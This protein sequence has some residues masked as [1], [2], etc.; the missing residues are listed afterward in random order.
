[1]ERRDY[2]L[3]EIEKIGLLLRMLLN[4][5]TSKSENTSISIENQ[6]EEE[7]ELFLNE[8]GFDIDDFLSLQTSGIE[9]YLSKFSGIRGANIELLADVLREIGMKYKSKLSKAYLEKALMLYE[10]CNS[11]DKTYSFDRERKIIEIKDIIR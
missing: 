6:F 5:I 8:M 2:L 4:K 9:D 11:L 1:M 10:H 7:K 3:Q